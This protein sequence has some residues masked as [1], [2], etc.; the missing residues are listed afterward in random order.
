MGPLTCSLLEGEDAPAAKSLPTRHRSTPRASTVLEIEREQLV[1]DV[2]GQAS[3]FHGCPQLRLFLA[4]HHS[5]GR[6][7]RWGSRPQPRLTPRRPLSSVP[8]HPPHCGAGPHPALT[9][10]QLPG[11]PQPRPSAGLLPL[12][13]KAK[14]LGQE[15]KSETV[16]GREGPTVPG[17]ASASRVL[18]FSGPS[19]RTFQPHPQLLSPLPSPPAP[20]V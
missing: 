1:W 12:R 5:L 15:N 9:L 14:G 13:P 6:R 2:G 3:E 4:H 18:P 19:C 17:R 8:W 20:P 11:P 16:G 7:N 10:P